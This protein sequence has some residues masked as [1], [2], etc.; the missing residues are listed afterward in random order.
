[1][2]A[3]EG[4]RLFESEEVMKLS[5]FTIILT[6]SPQTHRSRTKPTTQVSLDLYCA[7]IKPLVKELNA[8]KQ[9][10]KIDARSTASTMSKKVATFVI[11]CH[12]TYILETTGDD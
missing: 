5:D 12:T 1:M 7:R 3:I 9:I 10:L 4:H 8:S 6:G 2:T 11:I